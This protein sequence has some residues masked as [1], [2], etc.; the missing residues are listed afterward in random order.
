MAS[1]A[2]QAWHIAVPIEVVVAA[3]IGIVCAPGISEASR[4]IALFF[5]AALCNYAGALVMPTFYPVTPTMGSVIAADKKRAHR[6]KPA[7]V[8]LLLFMGQAWAITCSATWFMRV[9]HWRFVLAFIIIASVARISSQLLQLAKNHEDVKAMDLFAKHGAEVLPPKRTAPSQKQPA[10]V[11]LQALSSLVRRSKAPTE[12]PAAST[13]ET[14]D[15]LQRLRVKEGV[16]QDKVRVFYGLSV[17]ASSLHGVALI[18]IGFFVHKSEFHHAPFAD[19][20]FANT[21]AAGL[22]SIIEAVLSWRQHEWM[23]TKESSVAF[24]AWA[25]IISVYAGYFYGFCSTMFIY[26]MAFD[27]TNY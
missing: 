26:N 4:S 15:E 24:W 11:Q 8:Y 19:V 20:V 12:A 7:L 6:W 25:N 18:G 23:S 22:L 21:I 3:I 9:T 1:A 27:E 14:S 10:G 13:D 16:D 5:V 17:A 2:P